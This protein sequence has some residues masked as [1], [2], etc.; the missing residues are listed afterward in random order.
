MISR[1]GSPGDTLVAA[2][3]ST[4]LLSAHA[5]KRANGDVDVMLINKDPN[6]D[7]SVSLSY[8]GFTP[9]SGTPTAYSYLKNGH[10]ITSAA[11]GSATS[12]TVPAYSVVVVQLHS[13]GGATASNQQ[14]TLG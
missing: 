5:V 1:L 14:W 4:S 6:N 10:S 2:S 7:A 8:N 9:G 12:Q 3:S 13:G 11:T